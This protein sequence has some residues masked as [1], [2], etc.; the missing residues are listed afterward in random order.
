[1][2]ITYESSPSQ[3]IFLDCLFYKGAIWQS[4]G[5]GTL[6]VTVYKKAINKYLYKPASSASPE[7]SLVAV[8]M[9]EL[10]RLAR[11]CSDP[12]RYAKEVFE[13][14]DNLRARGYS[15]SLL[16]TAFKR[17]PSWKDRDRLIN[18]IISRSNKSTKQTTSTPLVLTFNDK[19]DNH[20]PIHKVRS[21][22]HLLPQD[23]DYTPELM[24][25]KARKPLSRDVVSYRYPTQPAT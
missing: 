24:C 16:E 10:H 9:A 22:R 8:A 1:M 18:R 20:P 2:R 13:L 17:A 7:H 15:P 25:W 5:D 14:Y 12:F 19:F 21:I 3:V 23:L 4:S 6:D 11:R